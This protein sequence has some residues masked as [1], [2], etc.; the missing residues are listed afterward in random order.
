MAKR[1]YYIQNEIVLCTYAAMYDADDFGGTFR[2]EDL[3]RRSPAS[4]RMKIQNIASMLDEASIRRY[5]NISPLTGL[6]HGQSGRVTNWK[7]VEPLT[8]LPKQVFLHQCLKIV[9]L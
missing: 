1:N 7:A 3:T 5:N 2:I 8:K 6:P 9:G 4:I